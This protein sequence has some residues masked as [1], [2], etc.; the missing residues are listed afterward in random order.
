VNR[1]LPQLPGVE[2]RFVDAAGIRMHVAE[3]GAGDPLVLLH[4][5]P[6]HWWMW[7]ELIPPLAER[8]R[9]I[10]PDLRGFGWSDAPPG[11]Y[12]KHR[13]AADVLALLGVLEVDRFRLA[14]HDWGGMAGF[15]LCLRQPERVERYLALGTVHPWTK[16]DLRTASALWRFWYQWVI[17]APLAGR[18]VMQSVPRFAETASRFWTVNEDAWSDDDRALFL[19]QFRER[20]RAE[21]TVSLYRSIPRKESVPA[22]RGTTHRDRLTVPTLMLHGRGDGAIHPALLRGYEPHADDMRLEII[23][24]CGHFLPEE[25]PDLVLSRALDF[26]AAP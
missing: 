13:F 24:G 16:V 26:F 18:F 3:A 12:D 5:W 7:R 15:E 1:P 17:S 10:A 22:I 19:D 9:V 14:G 21:A 11:P 2:H 6:Q 20:E 23:D 8:Y 25:C 4:G